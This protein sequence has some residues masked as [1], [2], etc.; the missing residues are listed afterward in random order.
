M[1][2]ILR[3]LHLAAFSFSA[4]GLA[5]PVW[6]EEH[7]LSTLFQNDFFLGHD[8][9]GYTNGIFFADIT[10][11]STGDQQVEP[12]FLLKPLAP[13]LG[14][15]AATLTAWSFGQIMVTPRDISRAEPDPNDIPY[16]GA[17]LFRSAQVYVHDD[18]AE[19]LAVD[20]GVIGPASGAAQ[21]QRF[22]HHLTGSDQAQGWDTQ[23][24]NKFSLGLER[25]RTLRL[26]SDSASWN[27]TGGDLILLGGGLLSNLESSAGA[28]A[29]VRYGT[30][31]EKSFP[32]AA[33]L[34]LH[35]AD[36]ILL[37]SDWFAFASIS[38]DRLFNYVGVGNDAPTGSN[39]QLRKIRVLSTAGIAYG[40]ESASLAFSIQNVNSVVKSSGGFQ[41]YGSLTYTY[42]MK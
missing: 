2:K 12:S 5:A 40:W 21:T 3:S 9:G 13:L 24:P 14:L 22:V 26:S 20:I 23:V 32:A 33:K 4:L 31:L 16:A 38:A 41:T 36:P 27:N 28:G 15:P 42:H 18:M 11:P 39:T 7:Y 30:G 29:L 10:A 8:G 35:G 25:Y 1:K 37:K 6:A 19:I 34:S 17:L